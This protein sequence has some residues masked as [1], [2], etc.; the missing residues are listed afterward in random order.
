MKKIIGVLIILI[1]IAI[2]TF[3]FIKVTNNKEYEIEIEEITNFLY[4]KLYENE[5]YGVI[6]DSGNILVP[7]KYDILEIP[8]PSKAVFVGSIKQTD[9]QYK[10]EVINDKNEQIL[11]NYSRSRAFRI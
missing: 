10:T 7:A 2:A 11:E 1:I 9:E 4:F 6:D 5:K 8:N 3:T